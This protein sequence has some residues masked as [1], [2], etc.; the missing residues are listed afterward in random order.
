MYPL[1]G[2]PNGHANYQ[3]EIIIFNSPTLPTLSTTTDSTTNHIVNWTPHKKLSVL[4]MTFN[5]I[6]WRGS[7]SRDLWILWVW[8]ASS[9]IPSLFWSRMIVRLRVPSMGQIDLFE[10]YLYSIGSCAKKYKK[11][12]NPTKQN[13]I[14]QNKKSP[15]NKNKTKIENTY[16]K[17]RYKNVNMN[18][19]GT[20]TSHL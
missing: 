3:R 9:L 7:S 20:R 15:R 5:Y 8:S 4:S 6:W 14:K 13:L 17:E 1:H 10:N 16:K 19:Q 2:T 12:K 11:K 18:V